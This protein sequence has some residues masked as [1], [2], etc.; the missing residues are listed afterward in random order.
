MHGR[1]FYPLKK[2][3][4]NNERFEHIPW[5]KK[6][7]D[8]SRE[9]GVWECA[10]CGELSAPWYRGNNDEMTRVMRDMQQNSCPR[11]H[12]IIIADKSLANELMNNGYKI[13]AVDFGEYEVT[14]CMVKY[15]DYYE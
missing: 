14:F 3:T 4:M 8:R 15:T 5:E 7:W 1:N 10:T 2:K 13:Q 6:A 11:T 12:N 9:Q